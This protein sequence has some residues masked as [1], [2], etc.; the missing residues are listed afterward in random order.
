MSGASSMF[1]RMVLIVSFMSGT[2]T[3]CRCVRRFVI[4]VSVEF[5]SLRPLWVPALSELEVA[6][7]IGFEIL[8]GDHRKVIA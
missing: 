2:L 7:S 8:E 5:V 4:T 3:L 1:A 6:R